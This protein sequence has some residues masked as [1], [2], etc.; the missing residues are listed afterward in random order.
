MTTRAKVIDAAAQRATEYAIESLVAELH[1]HNVILLCEP[2]L[3]DAAVFDA[4]V[5]LRDALDRAQK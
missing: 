1:E 4:A 2:Q 5:A 3:L